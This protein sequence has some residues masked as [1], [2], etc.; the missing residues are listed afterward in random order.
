MESSS[1]LQV[2]DDNEVRVVLKHATHQ[3]I[4]HDGYQYYPLTERNGE[5]LLQPPPGPLRHS[6]D[7]KT[8]Q[9]FRGHIA[10]IH[11][12]AAFDKGNDGNAE[13][14]H[15]L[16][17][18]FIGN[19]LSGT[20]GAFTGALISSSSL[21]DNKAFIFV[22][23]GLCVILLANT[24]Y[25][26]YTD[27]DK[28]PQQYTRVV[29]KMQPT[30]QT[31]FGYRVQ[32]DKFTDLCGL[33]CR[34]YVIFTKDPSLIVIEKED[35]RTRDHDDGDEEE[36][37][38]GPYHAPDW[39]PLEGTWNKV[40]E[41]VPADHLFS[42]LRYFFEASSLIWTFEGTAAP[43]TFVWDRIAKGRGVFRIF[44]KTVHTT[45]RVKQ[46]NSTLQYLN[47]METISKK[48][49]SRVRQIL[50]DHSRLRP[51]SSASQEEHRSLNNSQS[52][53]QQSYY[54]LQ[55]D[56]SVWVVTAFSLTKYDF[57]FLEDMPSNTEILQGVLEQQ[58]TDS[59]TNDTCMIWYFQRTRTVPVHSQDI[60]ESCNHDMA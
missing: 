38:Y 4:Q 3:P 45:S 24:M 8:W 15:L 26:N 22:Y 23:I 29:D 52:Q 34:C 13:A 27:R 53:H 2:E 47:V 39:M 9:R 59:S 5:S 19:I 46:H 44:P 58:H 20:W 42:F 50:R 37:A 1:P 60:E 57:S 7:A 30:F 28:L 18:R 10:A 48:P 17:N 6:I 36:E 49:N 25:T 31:K 35:D 12:R 33:R 54:Y 14:F 16:G 55:G 41:K 32:L 40:H 21:R 11:L 43:D 51:L 56:Q